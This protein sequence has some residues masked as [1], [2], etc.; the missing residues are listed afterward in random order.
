MMTRNSLRQAIEV[1]H[2]SLLND[3]LQ[4]ALDIQRS[5]PSFAETEIRAGKN[6]LK[7]IHFEQEL[8]QAEDL[9]LINPR[10]PRL[11]STMIQLRQD[12]MNTLDKDQR[13]EIKRKLRALC[14][15]DIHFEV[16]VRALKW[17]KVM[18]VWLYPEVLKSLQK[19]ASCGLEELTLDDLD[20]KEAVTESGYFLNDGIMQV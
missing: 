2:E 7:L 3:S 6:L 19:S 4:N 13:L 15:S 1:V 12:M 14:K 20:E 10:M 5:Y 18:A 17:S 8:M 16:V 11:T 9:P